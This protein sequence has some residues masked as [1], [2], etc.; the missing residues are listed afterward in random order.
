MIILSIAFLFYSTQR[1]TLE[2]VV[3]FNHKKCLTWFHKYTKDLSDTLGIY[4]N[5]SITFKL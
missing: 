4:K 3:V 5:N 1:T 2:D